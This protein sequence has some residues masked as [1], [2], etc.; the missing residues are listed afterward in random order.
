[1]HPELR[2][3][4]RLEA[5]RGDGGRRLPRFRGLENRG[6]A[7]QRFIGCGTVPLVTGAR[8]TAAGR[9]MECIAAALKSPDKVR[10]FPLAY[11]MLWG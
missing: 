10:I 9:Q 3:P 5:A 1:M 8:P 6:G 7:V 4:V 11:S 2:T